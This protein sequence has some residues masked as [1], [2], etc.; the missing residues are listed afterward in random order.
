METNQAL[1]PCYTL[2][3]ERNVRVAY[4][5]SQ[6]NF[7]SLKVPLKIQNCSYTHRI[8]PMSTCSVMSSLSPDYGQRMTSVLDL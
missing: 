3:N 8:E 7:H 6:S 2:A 1:W 5:N 4:E